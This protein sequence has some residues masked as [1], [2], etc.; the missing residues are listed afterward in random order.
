MKKAIYPTILEKGPVELIDISIEGD[1]VRG[2]GE[3]EHHLEVL[4]VSAKGCLTAVLCTML[5]SLE[6]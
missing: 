1:R 2:T 4:F 6:L 3:T 5:Y